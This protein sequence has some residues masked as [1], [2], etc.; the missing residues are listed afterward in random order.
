MNIKEFLTESI[1]SEV[2][3]FIQIRDLEDL[4][5]TNKFIL[6]PSQGANKFSEKFNYLSFS[7]IKFGGYA[8]SKMAYS[9]TGVILVLD[10]NKFNNHF[11]GGPVDYW[12]RD[13][14]KGNMDSKLTADENEERVFSDKNTISSALKYIKEIH[15]LVKEEE[16][17]DTKTL[18]LKKECDLKN[19][20]CFVYVDKK[21]WRLFDKRKIVSALKKPRFYNHKIKTILNVYY[22]KASEEEKNDL[23]KYDGYYI[24]DYITTL[25]NEIHNDYHDEHILIQ[26]YYDL[27]KKHKIRDDK[28]F[29]YKILLPKLEKK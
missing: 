28:E 4:L 13:F 2:Y 17:Y 7:R 21:A 29:Y 8:R 23:L 20:P 16:K 14:R 3:R 10:G 5:K 12:S 25:H 24:K 26:K 6:A 22:N 27:K 11:K 19:I 18:K 1:S 15:I 9:D